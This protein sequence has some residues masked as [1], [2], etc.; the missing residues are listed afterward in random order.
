MQYI[1]LTA[2]I[3]STYFGFVSAGSIKQDILIVE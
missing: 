1:L 3:G 2:T